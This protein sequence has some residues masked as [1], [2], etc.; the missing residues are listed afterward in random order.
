MRHGLDR[1]WVFR[2]G[3]CIGETFGQGW[4]MRLTEWDDDGKGFINGLVRRLHPHGSHP[5]LSG[6]DDSTFR[7]HTILLV[8]R[9]LLARFDASGK[10]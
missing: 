5:G 8:A 1:R 3:R 4:M 10:I 9:L 6:Q 7:L 2:R